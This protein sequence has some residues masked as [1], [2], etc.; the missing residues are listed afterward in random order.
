MG[1]ML[2]EEITS[3]LTPA[4]LFYLARECEKAGIISFAIDLYTEIFNKY[5]D[6][7]EADESKI[8]IQSIADRYA[9]EGKM[10]LFISLL[11][12]IKLT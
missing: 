11:N 4:N 2:Q 3:T 1:V 12:R 7:S 9:A 8:A 5:P 10:S 6:T